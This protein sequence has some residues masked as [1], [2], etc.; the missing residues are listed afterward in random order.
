VIKAIA[1]VFGMAVVL[2]LAGAI[3]SL[4]SRLDGF[5]Q[6]RHLTQEQAEHIHR[7][8]VQFSNTPFEVMTPPEE[9]PWELVLTVAKT[10]RS[11]GW[12]WEP[13]PEGAGYLVWQPMDPDLPPEGMTISNRFVITVPAAMKP[14][15]DILSWALKE[16]RVI[17]MEEVPVLVDSRLT[18]LVLIAGT[19]R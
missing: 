7:V 1:A 13:F 5:L 12:K 11:G 3:A 10:L 15:A 16:P 14:V 4:Q 18:R 6:P 17:G 9:E 2:I 8:A 19:K